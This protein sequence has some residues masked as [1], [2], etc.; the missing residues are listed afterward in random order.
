MPFLNI[1]FKCI[2]HD[3]S[4]KCKREYSFVDDPQSHTK[5]FYIQ[6]RDIMHSY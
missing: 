5:T 2:G 1:E 6:R 4:E 3:T